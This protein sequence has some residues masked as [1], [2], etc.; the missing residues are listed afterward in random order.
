M[1]KGYAQLWWIIAAAVIALLVIIFLLVW[2]KGSGEKAFGS[3]DNSIAGLSDCDK[4][5]VADI[6]DRCP[7]DPS[8]QENLASGQECPKACVNDKKGSDCIS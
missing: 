3:V 7:C 2:V 6:F 8:I 5:H 4:D 1:K